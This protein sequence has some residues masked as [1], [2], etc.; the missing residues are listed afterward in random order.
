[1]TATAAGRSGRAGGMRSAGSPILPGTAGPGALLAGLVFALWWHRPAMVDPMPAII[2]IGAH[3][4]TT[5]LLLRGARRVGDPALAPL[6][7]TVQV[8]AAIGFVLRMRVG[9]GSLGSL[10]AY[11]TAV[12]AGVVLFS[13]GRAL[14]AADRLPEGTVRNRRIQRTNMV[15]LTL[16]V[17]SCALAL[18]SP[19]DRGAQIGLSLG[20][21]HI[22]PT[23]V[24]RFCLLG[25]IAFRL[26]APAD[27]PRLWGAHRPSGAGW[28]LA[29]YALVPAVLATLIF[30]KLSDLGPAVV[31]FIGIVGVVVHLTGR[32]RYAVQATIGFLVLAVLATAVHLGVLGERLAL[33]EDPFYKGAH[34]AGATLHQPGMALLAYARGGMLGA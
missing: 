13:L 27:V 28:M 24:F 5:A 25:W 17:G 15:L 21:L 19:V 29:E 23:E 31:L 12:V 1:M 3:T 10:A 34:G 6:V 18:A 16:T 9:V 4:A 20:P 26:R 2:T 11:L 22:Q 33:W 30:V 7:I 14:A 32:W 8:L